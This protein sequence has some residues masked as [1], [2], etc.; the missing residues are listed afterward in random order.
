MFI[1]KLFVKFLLISLPFII[2]SCFYRYVKYAVDDENSV[3]KFFSVPENIQFANTGS[4]HGGAID[5]KYWNESQNENLRNLVKFSFSKPTQ[6]LIFDY[7]IMRQYIKKIEKGSPV[8]ILCSYFEIDGVPQEES[9]EYLNKR[10]YQFL[11]PKFLPGWNLV[12]FVK[13][14][15]LP[16][17]TT[18]DSLKSMKKIIK[19]KIIQPK[20]IPETKEK[21]NITKLSDFSEEKQQEEFSAAKRTFDVGF[22]RSGNDGLIYNKKLLEKIIDLCYKNDLRPI[23]LTTPIPDGTNKLYEAD[24]FFP[25]FEKFKSEILSDYS[26]IRWLDYSRNDF[27]SYNYNYFVDGHHMNALGKEAFM[28]VLKSDLEK[29][30]YL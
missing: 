13:Y 10:Y 3:S 14:R 7:E 22:T 4:S 23:I 18:K 24:G 5:Y 30:E 9:M 11:K 6:P 28:R 16:V 27:F 21:N 19:E 12:N 8:V 2:L 15:Y 20:S 17:F 29:L 26:N 1:R 25:V